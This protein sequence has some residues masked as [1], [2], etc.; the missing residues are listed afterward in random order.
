VKPPH[1]QRI[2]RK[3]V[4]GFSLQRVSLQLNRLP[5]VYVGRPTKYGNPYKPGIVTD[6]ILTESVEDAVKRY[7]GYLQSLP[8]RDLQELLEPLRGKNLACWCSLSQKCH[9]DVLLELANPHAAGEG[10]TR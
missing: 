6:G 3:R 9:A 1:P 7:R 2:Q 10:N 5:C 4:R 8:V